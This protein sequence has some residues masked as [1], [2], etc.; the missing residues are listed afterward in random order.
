MKKYITLIALAI[1]TIL[2]CEKDDICIDETTPSLIFRFYNN[3]SQADLKS[4]NL[5]SVWVENKIKIE[6]YVNVSL[7]SIAIPLDLNENNTTYIMENNTIK[8]TLKF[9]YTRSDIF[10]SRSCGY[11]TIFENLQIDSNT[12]NWIKNISINNSTINNETSAHISIFH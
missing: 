12:T 7:D 1:F 9:S 5:D 2:S 6:G 10:V 3:D 8:D 11:K 4:I